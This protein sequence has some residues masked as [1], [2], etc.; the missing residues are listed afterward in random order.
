MSQSLRE[1]RGSSLVELLVSL[2]LGAV[3]LATFSSL[4]VFHR[5]WNLRLLEEAR[6]LGDLHWAS[7]QILT[8]L[9]QAGLAPSRPIDGPTFTMGLGHF[10]RHA[11]LDGDGS[12]HKYST[13]AVT[14]YL[15]GSQALIRQVGRQRMALL[16]NL[17]PDGFRLEAFD[18]QGAVVALPEGA[19]G[20]SAGIFSGVARVALRLRSQGGASV[21]TS[22][23]L[24]FLN[25]V[26]AW[27]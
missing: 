18:H 17:V 25:P 8:D 2:A 1:S 26:D 7:I 12:I 21:E 10:S 11:D 13:E 3:L 4:L 15:S 9:R 22:V 5:H 27:G 14:F 23:A 16:E 20:I 6:E 19:A 24:P